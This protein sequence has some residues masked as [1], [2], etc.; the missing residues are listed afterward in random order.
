[1]RIWDIYLLKGEIFLFELALGIIQIQEK[2]L[3]NYSVTE[4]LRNLK[5]FNL[6]LN[7]DDLFDILQDIDIG[8]DYRNFLYE[9]NLAS[10]KGALLQTFMSEWI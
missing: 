1:M 2:D 10:E 4:I 7:E 5:T 6:K 8:E 9:I 3:K